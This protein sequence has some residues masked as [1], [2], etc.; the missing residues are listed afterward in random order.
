MEF[1]V[2]AQLI[3]SQFKGFRFCLPEVDYG[4]EDI[5]LTVE[6]A[7][8]EAEGRVAVTI[9]VGITGDRVRGFLTAF[10]FEKYDDEDKQIEKLV[11]YINEFPDLR[12]SV[13]K[14]LEYREE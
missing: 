7:E 14:L 10:E 13:E 8:I 1:P 2:F 4:R 12:D 6:Y 9:W 11:G 5:Q 3:V